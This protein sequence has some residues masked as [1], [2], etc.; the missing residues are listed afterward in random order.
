MTGREYLEQIRTINLKVIAISEEIAEIRAVL[1]AQAIKYDREPGHPT[2]SDKTFTLIC[3]LI[4]K[5]DEL[6][7][8]YMILSDKKQE[9]KEVL[10]RLS[11]QIYAEVLY[12]RYFEFKT[13]PVIAQE[14]HYSEDHVKALCRKA[15]KEVEDNTKYH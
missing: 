14:V 4:D 13:Y 7:E 12:K 9:V 1:G 3:K 10:Y 5:Q 8:Q 2:G 15:L 6:M 11:H